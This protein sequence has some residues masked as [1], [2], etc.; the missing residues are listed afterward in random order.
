MVGK[1]ILRYFLIKHW[2]VVV[3]TRSL[4]NKVV[5]FQIR[6]QNLCSPVFI[7]CFSYDPGVKLNPLADQALSQYPYWKFYYY[8]YYL[9]I[10]SSKPILIF[11]RC[12]NS[13]WFISEVELK[14]YKIKTGHNKLR[15]GTDSAD[16][17]HKT[18]YS[19]MSDLIVH[20]LN[21]TY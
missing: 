13:C 9:L 16:I 19:L 8:Y 10:Y 5:N 18:T 15:V 7:G 17:I 3:I 6:V 1:K 12:H 20:T 14:G 21:S 2:L 11:S 4:K